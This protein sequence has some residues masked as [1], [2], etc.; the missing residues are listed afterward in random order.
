MKEFFAKLT[1]EL[2]PT[3]PG[4][5]KLEEMFSL[6]GGGENGPSSYEMLFGGGQP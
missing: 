6:G 2:P 3:K 4:R 1:A 5:P